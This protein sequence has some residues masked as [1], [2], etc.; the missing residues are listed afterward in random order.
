MKKE[1]LRVTKT[2]RD[3]RL[4]LLQL[5]KK[6][7]FE[8]ISVSDICN[9]AIINRMTFY[10]HFDDKYDLLNHT[11]ETTVEE[12]LQMTTEKFD[13]QKFD[14]TPIKFCTLLIDV[15]LDYCAKNKEL[16]QSLMVKDGG[17]VQ[18]LL[19]NI[20]RKNIEKLIK[21][22]DKLASAKY[23]PA[24][25]S[26]FMTGGISYLIYY[27]LT[28]SGEYTREQFAKMCN[29]FLTDLLESGVLF[30]KPLE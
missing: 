1:D 17:I 4:A 11:M 25:I 6:Y 27:W 28:H 10:K 23:S 21:E 18:D 15:V 13:I 20:T 19:F 16:L 14:E 29:Q 22:L 24:A 9:E 3:L 26:A 7:P 2:K 8:K 30:E 12:V 5:L